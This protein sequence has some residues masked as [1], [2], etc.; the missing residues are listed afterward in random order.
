MQAGLAVQQAAK[1][2]GVDI[3]KEQLAP[4][5]ESPL[6]AAFRV[7]RN[8]VAKPVMNC[9]PE[10]VRMAMLNLAEKGVCRL[11]ESNSPPKPAAAEKPA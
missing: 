11:V 1:L 3:V 4:S 5:G 2:K 9:T 8:L 10:A 6:D 7:V